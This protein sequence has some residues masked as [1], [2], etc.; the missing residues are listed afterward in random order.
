MRRAARSATL[1][2]AVLLACDASAPTGGGSNPA[3]RSLTGS[4]AANLTG[5]AETPGPGDPDGSGTARITL[6]QARGE[7]CFD[8]VVADVDPAFAAHIHQGEAGVAGPIAVGLAPP[9]MGI[10]SDCLAGVDPALIAA[11]LDGPSGYYVNVHT[12]P[13]PA[14]ALRGQLAR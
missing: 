6:D 5:A 1:L 9:T 2:T 14:G 3:G 8:L 7:L 10:A 4:L 12:Q 13:Y 11:I